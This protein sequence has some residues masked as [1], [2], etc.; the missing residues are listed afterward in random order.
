M[1]KTYEN[2]VQ[3]VIDIIQDGEKKAKKIAEVTMQEVREKM[4]LG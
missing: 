1:R 4:K 3:K 2:N